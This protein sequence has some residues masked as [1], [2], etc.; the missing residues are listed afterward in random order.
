MRERY[1]KKQL[2]KSYK[3]LGA[4]LIYPLHGRVYRILVLR[5][6]SKMVTRRLKQVQRKYKIKK[7]GQDN[8]YNYAEC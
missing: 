8:Y 7:N 5:V 1:K 4:V 3:S 6:Y 2:L